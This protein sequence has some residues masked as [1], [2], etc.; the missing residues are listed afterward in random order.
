MSIIAAFSSANGA[1]LFTA[2][3]MFIYIFTKNGIGLMH[4]DIT[5]I[6]GHR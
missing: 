3:V 6:Y 2:E 4:K 5:H 1:G